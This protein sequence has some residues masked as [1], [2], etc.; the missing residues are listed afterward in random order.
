MVRAMLYFLHVSEHKST[1]VISRGVINTHQQRQ[2][3]EIQRRRMPTQ[4][5]VRGLAPLPPPSQP[6]QGFTPMTF[7]SRR[8]IFSAF[9][10]DSFGASYRVIVGVACV[11][12]HA[13]FTNGHGVAF[14]DW[15][16]R[17]RQGRLNT[18]RP[19]QATRSCLRFPTSPFSIALSTPG[20]IHPVLLSKSHAFDT[21]L[22]KKKPQH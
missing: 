1:D 16:S 12:R 3:A 9:S 5:A 18:W 22:N 4:A 10:N 13:V 21:K 7:L 19:H 8:S 20:D 15:R 6:T 17:S 11:K 14:G 2:R